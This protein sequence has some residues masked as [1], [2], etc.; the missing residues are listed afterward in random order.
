MALEIQERDTRILKFVFACKV[1]SY[2]QIVNR[3]FSERDKSAGYRRIRKLCHDGYLK[4]LT[5]TSYDTE[6]KYVEATEKAW[7]VIR[8]LW[9]FEVDRPHFRSES[10]FH[11]IRLTELFFRFEKLKG[12]RAFY[13]ENLLQSSVALAKEPNLADLAKIQADAA[14]ILNGTGNRL[15][16]FGVELEISKKTPDRY[17]E[18]LAAYYTTRK[19]AGVIYVCSEREIANAIARTDAEVR[20]EKKSIVFL[21]M[22]NKTRESE[23]AIT[24]ET[25]QGQ[26]LELM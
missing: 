17:A 1:A 10:P 2:R 12:F 22:E 14:L 21:G 26:R 4:P 11:D 20:G 7:K 15:L 24:L 16:T 18:K 6:I 3:C 5:F 8:E 19:L 9:S 13:T 25:P 23:G